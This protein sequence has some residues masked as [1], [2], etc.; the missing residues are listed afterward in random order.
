[1]KHQKIYILVATIIAITILYICDQGLELPYVMKI[2][3]KLILFFSLPMFY[4]IQTKKNIVLE[5]IR[6]RDKLFKLKLS[7]ILSLFI[8]VILI[9]TYLIVKPTINLAIF[10]VEFEQKYKI[11]RDNILLYG[12]YFSFFNSLLEEFFF[13]GFM[14]L[15]LKKLNMHKSAYILSSLAF[16]LYHIGN[17]QNWFNIG[18]FLLALLGL[19]V[20]GLIFAYLDDK[21]NTFFNSWFVHVCADLAIV[22]IGYDM[23]S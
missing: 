6:N 3:V 8:I 21:Q 1:M 11:H 7:H 23:L 10:Q 9:A 14:F 16:S 12:I 5:S 15:G 13:R 19:F 2:G 18:I 22:W 20:G 17:I 4:I